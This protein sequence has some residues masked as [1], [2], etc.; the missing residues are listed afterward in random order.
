MEEKATRRAREHRGELGEERPRGS[1][2]R[3]TKRDRGAMVR[4]GRRRGGNTGLQ[5][6]KERLKGGRRGEQEGSRKSIMGGREEDKRR[7]GRGPSCTQASQTTRPGDSGEIVHLSGCQGGSQVL[8]TVSPS[9]FLDP[10]C[11]RT[12]S[13][14]PPEEGKNRLLTTSPLPCPFLTKL[15]ARPGSFSWGC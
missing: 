8:T 2:T 7:M 11:S 4:G 3:K 13:P 10:S 6:Q 15:Q 1:A 14:P 5:G 12:C 9:S